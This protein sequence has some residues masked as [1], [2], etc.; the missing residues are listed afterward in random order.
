M[1]DDSRRAPSHKVP[2][3]VASVRQAG[4]TRGNIRIVKSRQKISQKQTVGSDLPA[5]SEAWASEPSIQSGFFHGAAVR[6]G[7]SCSVCGASA[8]AKVRWNTDRVVWSQRAAALSQLR[9]WDLDTG[10]IVEH[11]GESLPRNRCCGERKQN[12]NGE[13]GGSYSGGRGGVYQVDGWFFAKNVFFMM[14][15]SW[16]CERQE[17]FVFYC[18]SFSSSP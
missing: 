13:E 7:R 16:D 9:R 18:F 10:A 12:N 6:G 17:P 5:G 4:R 8:P 14:F 3:K 1:T 11:G 2:V 15:F